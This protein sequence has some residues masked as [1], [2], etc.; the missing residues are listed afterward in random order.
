MSQD[1]I[2]WT[3]PRAA[4]YSCFHTKYESVLVQGVLMSRT[5]SRGRAQVPR[6][7]SVFFILNMKASLCRECS[8]LMS[9]DNITWTCASA[10]FYSCFY[11]KYETV[12]V[13]GVLMSQDNITWTCASAASTYRMREGSEVI[14]SFLP[15]SH[16]VAQVKNN[17]QIFQLEILLLLFYC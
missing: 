15:F 9:Q 12:L 4:C 13:Q 16:I 11:T 17:S 8:L 1:N 10:A 7:L 6:F 14:V 3:C 5:T 2:T